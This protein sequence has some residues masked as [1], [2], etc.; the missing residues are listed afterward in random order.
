MSLSG[1]HLQLCFSAMAGIIRRW[2]GKEEGPIDEI[3]RSPPI[4]SAG[5][6]EPVDMVEKDGAISTGVDIN[7][8]E[9]NRRLK[10]FERA[11]RWDPNLDDE[12]L[13]EIDEAVNAHDPRNEGKL[14]DEVLENSPYPE[15]RWINI[16]PN[17]AF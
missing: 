16:F 1:L 7:E 6:T 10:V 5:S 14:I 12:Q 2:K 8:V 13:D 17:P 3:A 11:H 9:A 4:S 15:V